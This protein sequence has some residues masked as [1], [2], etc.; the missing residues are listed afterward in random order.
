MHKECSRVFVPSG[1][2]TFLFSTNFNNTFILHSYLLPEVIPC[3]AAGFEDRL[4]R[5]NFL[6]HGGVRNKLVLHVLYHTV[7][8]LYKTNHCY[9][10]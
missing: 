3:A 7:Q 9:T 2:C 8:H 6:H 5:N 10:R 1:F 4:A